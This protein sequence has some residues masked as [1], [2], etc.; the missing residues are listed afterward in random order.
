MIP[1]SMCGKSEC[2]CIL[3]HD[4]MYRPSWL[5]YSV[6][7]LESHKDFYN[8]IKKFEDKIEELKEDC[9]TLNE[10]H[11]SVV[12]ENRELEKEFKEKISKLE[13]DL[14]LSRQGAQMAIDLLELYTEKTRNDSEGKE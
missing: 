13:E 1:C 8:K 2:T 9:S 4:L 14:R 10:L 6:C 11:E 7:N 5:V 12:A 3:S